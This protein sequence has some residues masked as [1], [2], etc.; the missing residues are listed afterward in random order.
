[1][2]FVGKPLTPPRYVI[3]P[4]GPGAYIDLGFQLTR[5]RVLKFIKKPFETIPKRM[6]AH[7]LLR[8][9][10]LPDSDRLQIIN[11]PSL[12]ICVALGARH[13]VGSTEAALKPPDTRFSFVLF[14]YEN[15]CINRYEPWLVMRAK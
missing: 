14:M 2:V 13:D 4:N 12:G 3:L 11:L 8:G 10:A 15:V 6:A 9:R 7:R 5:C 1:M